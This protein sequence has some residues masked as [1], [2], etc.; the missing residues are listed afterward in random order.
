MAKDLASEIYKVSIQHDCDSENLKNIFLDKARDKQREL[1]KQLG[2]L[3]SNFITKNDVCK[4]SLRLNDDF[5]GGKTV[6]TTENINRKKPTEDLVC[7]TDNVYYTQVLNEE[8]IFLIKYVIIPMNLKWDLSG[9]N[10]VV[11]WDHWIREFK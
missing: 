8:S 3:I 6:T 5:Y 1:R 10:I 4:R 9:G 11:K 7:L 2:D